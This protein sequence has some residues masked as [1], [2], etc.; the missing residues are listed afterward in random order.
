MTRRHLAILTCACLGASAVP[1]QARQQTPTGAKPSAR[2]AQPVRVDQGVGDISPLNTSLLQVPADLRAD[3]NF[4]GVYQAPGRP[5]EFMRTAGAINAVFP[6]S[7]Y[8][9]TGG[10][11]MPIVPASTV[12]YIGQPL[13]QTPSHSEPAGPPQPDNRVYTARPVDG[14]LDPRPSQSASRPTSEATSV[15]D[16]AYRVSLLWRLTDR[17]K[18]RLAEAESIPG[19][20]APPIGP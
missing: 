14:P 4:Q 8:I 17:A 9:A 3:N 10:G 15:E 2:P 19:D 12:F 7:D 20:E 18:Q 11:L 16:N 13:P 6:R 5:G 1:C